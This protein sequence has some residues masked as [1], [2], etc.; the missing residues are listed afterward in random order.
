MEKWI[1]PSQELLDKIEDLAGP[2]NCDRRIMF[3]YPVFF[4]RGNM[5]TGVFAND[6]FI[7]L[8]QNE[9]E[10]IKEFSDKIICLEP[11]KGRVM[12]EYIVIPEEFLNDAKFIKKWFKISNLYVQS[13]PEKKRTAKKK[14]KVE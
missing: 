5:F 10:L 9:T 13:L 6:V 14:K 3:G 7:R 4:I 11:V 2:F 12:K 8:P 1:K